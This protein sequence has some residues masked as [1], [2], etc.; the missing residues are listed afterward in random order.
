MLNPTV[1]ALFPMK[2]GANGKKVYLKGYKWGEQHLSR[3][4]YND[5]LASKPP[6]G[7]CY[8]GLITGPRSGGLMVVDVDKKGD[9]DLDKQASNLRG[10]DLPQTLTVPTYSGGHHLF[11]KAPRGVKI[12]TASDIFGDKSGI[13]VR[14][15]GGMVVLY[16]HPDSEESPEGV[17][18]QFWKRL[19]YDHYLLDQ[20]IRLPPQA[21][22][23]MREPKAR[24][25]AA[26]VVQ[27]EP[28]W[29]GLEI[30]KGKRD[31]TLRD[32][33]WKW[34]HTTTDFQILMYAL[35]GLNADK[36]RPPVE[37]SRI[38]YMLMRALEKRSGNGVTAKR[39]SSNEWQ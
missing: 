19:M 32:I 33:I 28:S 1:H 11:F 13:D 27:S 2:I 8:L 10:L 21:L 18:G 17:S 39:S 20:A 23:M 25:Q 38:E 30:S 34:V 22:R 36:V 12:V 31:E 24:R 7:D 16:P 4:E 14:G 9:V 3:E 15:D 37:R 26:G 35:M 29:D 5:W 6:Y